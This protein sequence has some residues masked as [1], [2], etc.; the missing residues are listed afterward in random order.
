MIAIFGNSDEISAILKADIQA[1]DIQSGAYMPAK[2]EAAH[3]VVKQAFRLAGALRA[4]CC[5]CLD[6]S[7]GVELGIEADIWRYRHS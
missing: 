6:I 1:V 4:Y 7:K 3:A 5:F 2:L